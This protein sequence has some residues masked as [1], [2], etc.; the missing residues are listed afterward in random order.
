MVIKEEK[1]LTIS[2]VAS[3]IGDTE[4][5]ESIMTFIKQFKVQPVEK[6][7]EL[8]QE[9]KELDLLKLK[10]KYIVKIVDFMPEEPTELN[11]ILSD[12]NLDATEITKIL[13]VVKRY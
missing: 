9:L 7:L 13:D 5:I 8:K 11:K 1:P 3:L 6:A 4:R 10:E 12:L 2:E